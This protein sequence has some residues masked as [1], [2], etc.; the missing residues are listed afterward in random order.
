VSAHRTKDLPADVPMGGMNQPPYAEIFFG[1]IR[2]TRFNPC[3]AAH[4]GIPMSA[5]P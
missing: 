2:K 1:P 3:E 5:S 4:F